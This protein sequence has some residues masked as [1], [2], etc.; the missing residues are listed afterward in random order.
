MVKQ[1]NL[2]Q[3]SKWDA[4]RPD[5]AK[6]QVVLSNYNGQE[7]PEA[8]K[9][10]FENYVKQGGGFVV[11]HAADNS[12]SNWLEYNKMIGLG[13]WGG[14]TEKSGPYVYYDN[15]GNLVRDIM[16]GRGGGHGPK[17]EFMIQLRDKDHPIT[18]GMPEYWLHA[19]DELYDS[20][21][22][23]AENMTVLATAYSEKSKRHEPMMMLID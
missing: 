15:A 11:V 2:D 4:W 5:F 13:G 3:A 21:R 1:F 12:F 14:R 19:K 10:S 8:V 18:K 6:Y 9:T 17:H 16:V 22:G 7:W 23:P 20:L